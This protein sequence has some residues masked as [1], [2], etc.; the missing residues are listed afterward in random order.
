MRN[1]LSNVLMCSA[2]LQ[3]KVIQERHVGKV[4]GKET[5]PLKKMD[6]WR[7][8]GGQESFEPFPVGSAVVGLG[9][10]VL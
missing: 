6:S 7:E 5:S 1:S 9:E 8:T 3:V 2:A 4:C 10:A